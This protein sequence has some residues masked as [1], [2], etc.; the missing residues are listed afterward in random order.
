[1]SKSHGDVFQAFFPLTA[2]FNVPLPLLVLPGDEGWPYG[3]RLCLTAEMRPGQ[4]VNDGE[5]QELLE[6]PPPPLLPVDNSQYKCT[7]TA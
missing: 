1:M 3:N 6:E 4:P 7:A 5:L 2:Y